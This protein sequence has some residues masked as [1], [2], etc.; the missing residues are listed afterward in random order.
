MVKQVKTLK[1]HQFFSKGLKKDGAIPLW[2]HKIGCSSSEV[3]KV[4]TLQ[5]FIGSDRRK[6]K[7]LI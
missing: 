5:K 1:S 2:K 6:S 3:T 7:Q 4:S